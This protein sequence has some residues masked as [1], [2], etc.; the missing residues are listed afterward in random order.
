M[1]AVVEV[2][3]DPAALGVGGGDDPVPGVAEVVHALA[4]RARP[5]LL[6]GLAREEDLPHAPSLSAPAA[7][8]AGWDAAG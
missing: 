8:P 7:P 3:L 6:G 5:S 4:Q 1:R 2:A